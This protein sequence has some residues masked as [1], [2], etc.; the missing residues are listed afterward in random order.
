MSGDSNKSKWKA[1]V[2]E[3][4]TDSSEL[5]FLVGQDNGWILDS[6]ATCHISCK[7]EWFI[8]LDTKHSENVCVANGQMVKASDRGKIL[9]N[10]FNSSGTPTRVMME[11]VLYMP[12]IGSNLISVKQLT[13]KGF[14]V[15]FH[16]ETCQINMGNGNRQI[17]VGDIVGNL[18]CIRI[19]NK[20]NYVANNQ[21]LCIHQWHRILGHRD[22]EAVKKIPTSD[23]IEGMKLASCKLNCGHTDDCETC[24]KAK[25]TRLK[26]PKESENRSTNVLDLIHSDICG[27][28]QT[29]TPSGKRYLLTFIDDFSRFTTIYLL[30]EK[31]EAFQKFK[32]FHELVQNQFGRKI[33]MIRT[34]RGGEYLNTAFISYLNENGIKMQRTAP[35]SPA[36]NGVAERKNRTLIEMARCMLTD[37]DLEFIF[38]G[39]AVTTANFIHNRLAWKNITKT[40]YEHW[41]NKKPVYTNLKRFGANCFV[42]VPDEHRRKIQRH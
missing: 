20:V 31:S 30:K 5:L 3:H 17:T 34:D 4:D 10:F 29:K 22:M 26:F 19:A 1:N 13:S 24:I 6:G 14:K 8:D 2:V 40:P 23:L 11:N 9:V 28:M 18:Y 39:E 35:Y 42:K 41:Y 36:Q 38:W 12:S 15:D 27:P 25:M 21:K 32:E 37:A 33:K 16:G 7:R